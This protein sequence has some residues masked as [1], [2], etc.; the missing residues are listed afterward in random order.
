MASNP[1]PTDEISIPTLPKYQ[2]KI[3]DRKIPTAP[4]TNASIDVSH[5]I[6]LKTLNRFIPIAIIIPNS[7]VRSNTT[8]SMV[9]TMANPKANII[10]DIKISNINEVME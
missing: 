7:L 10:I 4:P 3:K 6:M 9:L 2:V 8:I 5:I 1:S